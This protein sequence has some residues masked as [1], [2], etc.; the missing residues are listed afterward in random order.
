MPGMCL[1]YVGCCLLILILNAEKVLPMFVS[2]FHAAFNPQAAFGG[3]VGMGVIQVLQIGVKRGA[4][5][6]EAGIGTAPMAHGNAK[7]NE[8]VSEGFV[9]MLGPFFDTIIVCTMTALVILVTLDPAAYG[10]DSGILLTTKAFQASLGNSGVYILGFCI[11]LFGFTSMLGF[12]NYNQKCWHFLFKG[13][14]FFNDKLFLIFYCSCLVIGAVSAATDVVNF[15]DIGCALMTIP[16]MIATLL[17]AKKVKS[18]TLDYM[19]KYQV[20]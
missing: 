12:A 3:A 18:S 6:N 20:G 1:I 10:S 11:L 7:T 13:R 2:I 17:L 15:I 4:F 9:A 16:N 14:W 19:E 8:P 5:S